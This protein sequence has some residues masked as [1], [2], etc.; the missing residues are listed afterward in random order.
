MA[1]LLW[2]E[3]PAGLAPGGLEL[4]LGLPDWPSSEWGGAGADGL[5]GFGAAP[6]GD[7]VGAPG[8]PVAVGTG[9]GAMGEVVG[10]GES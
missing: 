1:G 3:A 6:G 4:T 10:V 9:D 5:V 2:G 7:E 8:E